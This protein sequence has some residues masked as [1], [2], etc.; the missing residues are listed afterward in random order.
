MYGLF[1]HFILEKIA[2]RIIENIIPRWKYRLGN[3]IHYSVT[4]RQHRNI[5]IGTNCRLN[6]GNVLQAGYKNGKIILHDYVHCGPHV[7]M[8]AYDH[9]IGKGVFPSS[10]SGYIESDI[11]LKEGVWVG[12]NSTILRGTVVGKNS[13]IAA[14]SVVRGVFPENVIVGGIPARIIKELD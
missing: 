8:F 9:V 11:V 2:Y 3:K 1:R 14:G 5:V 4:I 7:C 6:V 13:V 10:E 12:A